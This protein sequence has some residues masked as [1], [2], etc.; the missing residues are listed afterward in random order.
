MSALEA[1]PFTAHRKNVDKINL[2]GIFSS[3]DGKWPAVNEDFV[4][5]RL[6]L[7]RAYIFEPS[8]IQI[9]FEKTFWTSGWIFLT[10][11]ALINLYIIRTDIIFDKNT[12]Q[13]AQHT[14]MS[15]LASLIAGMQIINGTRCHY[16]GKILKFRGPHVTPYVR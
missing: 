1:Q 12:A 13:S 7:V 2:T 15:A 3:L 14:R 10:L 16:W 8:R 9:R 4:E 5:R 6:F 11:D